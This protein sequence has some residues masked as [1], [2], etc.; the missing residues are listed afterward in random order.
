[1]PQIYFYLCEA[2][3]MR[4]AKFVFSLGLKMIPD[5]QYE[6]EKPVF[7][8]HARAYEPYASRNIL[9]FVTGPVLK[10]SV[11][12]EAYEEGGRKKFFIK[13]RHGFAYMD[14]F[15]PGAVE[16]GDRRIRPGFIGNYP[17][18]YGRDGAKFYPPENDDFVLKAIC[19]FIKRQSTAVRLANQTFWIGEQCMA[20]CKET[21]YELV[22]SGDLVL[23]KLPNG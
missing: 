20:L 4:L 16:S 7:I 13:P 3:K 17:F 2:E 19:S 1:M 18:Y 6:T 5:L 14:F 15:S 12:F 21:G 10:E 11:V 23:E 22:N 8:R 9:M